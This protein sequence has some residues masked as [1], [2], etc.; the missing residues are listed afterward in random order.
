MSA[1]I[2]AEAKINKNKK[3]QD[4]KKKGK[5]ENEGRGRYNRWNN[6]FDW[7]AKLMPLAV[8]NRERDSGLGTRDS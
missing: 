7:L 3:K 6:T 8:E 1:A 4:K 5:K 2:S